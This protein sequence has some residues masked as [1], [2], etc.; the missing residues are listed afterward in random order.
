MFLSAARVVFCLKFQSWTC[1]SAHREHLRPTTACGCQRYIHFMRT[2]GFQGLIWPIS[3]LESHL[4]LR[5]FG[6]QSAIDAKHAS[7]YSQPMGTL[8]TLSLSCS[9]PDCLSH[10]SI[11]P[12]PLTL[13]SFAQP[14]LRYLSRKTITKMVPRKPDRRRPHKMHHRAVR[15]RRSVLLTRR[16]FARRQV[17]Q[18]ASSRVTFAFSWKINLQLS[19]S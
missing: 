7:V 5:E 12:Y 1:L 3:W 16:N 8:A 10:S 19:E 11:L 17:R 15:G 2:C 6:C 13:C 4:F 18:S 14:L 9:G